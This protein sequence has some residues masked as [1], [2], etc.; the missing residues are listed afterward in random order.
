VKI[1][2][3]LGGSKKESKKGNKTQVVVFV[4]LE[5]LSGKRYY[6]FID[7]LFV[8]ERF[9]EFFRSQ[10]YNTTRTCRTNTR[11]ISELIDLKQKDQGDKLL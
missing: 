7:N 11:V 1:L 9:L 8:S 4:L 10:G 6:Y 5:R 2:V 3:D